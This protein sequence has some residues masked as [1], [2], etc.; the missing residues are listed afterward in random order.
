VEEG[1]GRAG[2]GGGFRRNLLLLH[3]FRLLLLR[4]LLILLGLSPF[5]GELLTQLQAISAVDI[6]VVITGLPLPAVGIE[7]EAVR[8]QPGL[9]SAVV[10]L[11]VHVA[12]LGVLES[13]VA[14]G[15][16]KLLGCNFF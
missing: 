3:F 8:A 13:A 7:D 5:E 10:A 14:L 6:E 1:E 15:T 9:R 4:L 12:L 16:L 11:V 2:E